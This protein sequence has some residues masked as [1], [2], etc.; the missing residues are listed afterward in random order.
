MFTVHPENGLT[1]IEVAEGVDV[2]DIVANTGCEFAVAEDLK[3]MRQIPVWS[4]QYRLTQRE[5]GIFFI[6]NLIRLNPADES[7]ETQHQ[8]PIPFSGFWN[9]KIIL[10]KLL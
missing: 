3:P 9:S 4:R 10:Q 5:R 7:I 6:E 1:L 2:A 8:T